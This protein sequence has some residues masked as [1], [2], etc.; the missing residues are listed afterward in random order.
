MQITNGPVPTTADLWNW[1]TNASHGIALLA[2]KIAQSGTNLNN[3]HIADQA[4]NRIPLP[5][6]TVQMT[7]AQHIQ[8]GL[9]LYRRNTYYW[10]MTATPDPS[11][12]TIYIMIKDLSA[13]AATGV[14]YADRIQTFMDA[15][16]NPW[17]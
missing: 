4:P 11:G 17:E 12:S 3:Y 6:P 7:G 1:H 16:P 5:S 13:N 9:A 10:V 2:T 14:A 8:S 15:D